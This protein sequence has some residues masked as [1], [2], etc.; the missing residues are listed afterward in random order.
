MAEILVVR[1][2]G[3]P[4]AHSAE[5]IVLDANGA[6]IGGVIRGSL[7]ELVTQV[8]NRR[9]VALIPGTDV[10]LAEPV[11]PAKA[12]SS[13]KL[14]Q[15][16]PYA[17]EEQLASDIE[18]LH[19]AIGRREP[20]Q[21][22]TP[23]AVITR[24]RMDAWIGVFTSA[25]LHPEAMYAETSGVPVVPNG[26]CVLIDGT[27]VY[28]KRQG[29][30]GAVIDVDP[31]I[32]GL[33][34]ALDSGTEAREHVTLY[35]TETDYERE[36]DLL[37]GLREFVASLQMK[38]LPDGPLPLLAA[39]VVN[40]PSVNLLQG[41]YAVAS[42]ARIPLAPW[43]YAA[44]LAGVLLLSHIG[45]KAVQYS[46][47][48]RQE[49]EIDAAIQQV[50]QAAMPGAPVPDPKDAR[51]QMEARLTAIRGSNVTGGFMGALDTLSSAL[52]QAPGTEV[53][54]LSYRSNTADVRLLAPNVGVLDQMRQSFAEQ[55]ANAE[56][57][58]ANPRD[59]KIE[60]RLQVRLA[61][62]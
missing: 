56:I 51:S 33:Q 54:A 37:E 53:E 30:P 17:L 12:K 16:V 62:A 29:K 10:L 28:V 50:F 13:S 14:A 19:F 36:R 26:V 52:Q 55:G 31:L 41:P 2:Q 47:L 9:L 39:T 32:E 61:G 49:A 44:A 15:L 60:G 1:V 22:A 21:M 8:G 6:R 45:Y 34:L 23:V 59:N 25:G 40:T 18:E 57:Q 20:K 46:Q 11:L 7:S 24:A 42:P 58:S 4:E 27:R 5:W 3:T 43:R 48:K 35:V 38:L